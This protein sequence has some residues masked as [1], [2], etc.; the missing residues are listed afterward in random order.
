MVLQEP[1]KEPSG[2]QKVFFF[3]KI[4]N[5]CNSEDKVA[6]ATAELEIVGVWKSSVKGLFLI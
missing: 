2:P 5:R 6:M 3:L 4:G 1:I